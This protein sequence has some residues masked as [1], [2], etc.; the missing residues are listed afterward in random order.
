MFNLVKF[1][2]FSDSVFRGKQ[3]HNGQKTI[4]KFLSGFKHFYYKKAAVVSNFC[5]IGKIRRDFL[6]PTMIELGCK[7]FMPFQTSDLH[8]V[9]W[10]PSNRSQFKIAFLRPLTTNSNLAKTHNKFRPYLALT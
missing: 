1:D 8:R 6:V 4:P 10:R 2:Y 3:V 5:L 9:D 7:T